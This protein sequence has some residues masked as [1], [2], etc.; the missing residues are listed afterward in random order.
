MSNILKMSKSQSSWQRQ[1]GFFL[2]NIW[3]LFAFVLLAGMTI[4]YLAIAQDILSILVLFLMGFL[5]YFF[6]S[7]MVIVITLSLVFTA[8]FRCTHTNQSLQIVLGQHSNDLWYLEGMKN[9]NEHDSSGNDTD[10]DDGDDIDISGVLLNY[11]NVKA[12]P[13]PSS[14]LEQSFTGGPPT[15]AELEKYRLQ[16]NILDKIQSLQPL[17][18][19]VANM[20]STWS[21]PVT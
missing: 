13:V 15:D 4:I 12:A 8:L 7:N 20:S 18:S 19:A 2:H 5:V 3:I 17:I 11:D 21:K 16:S 1:I 10:S 6:T 14:L 9:K